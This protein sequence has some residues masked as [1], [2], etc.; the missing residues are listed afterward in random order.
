[1]GEML[2]DGSRAGWVRNKRIKRRKVRPSRA[3]FA[4][5]SFLAGQWKRGECWLSF[6]RVAVLRHHWGAWLALWHSRHCRIM[7]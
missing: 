4:L 3:S 1:M 5:F 6:T 7:T 2:S